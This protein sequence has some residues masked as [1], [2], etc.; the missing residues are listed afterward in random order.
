MSLM[1]TS[2]ARMTTTTL[3]APAYVDGRFEA[4]AFHPLSFPSCADTTEHGTAHTA[5]VRGAMAITL[6]W[7][8]AG[9]RVEERSAMTRKVKVKEQERDRKK[10]LLIYTTQNS[11]SPNVNS[12]NLAS[13]NNN[14]GRS[15]S[16][17]TIGTMQHEAP[18]P[19]LSCPLL[20]MP[21]QNSISKMAPSHITMASSSLLVP[22]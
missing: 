18:V 7:R 9:R 15:K 5:A 11:T 21:V 16:P 1:H 8:Q 14:Y 10:E 12:G 6:I 4:P 19:C 2:C 17:T 3:S 22:S 20:A 13:L